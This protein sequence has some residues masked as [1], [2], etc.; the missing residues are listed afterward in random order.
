[1]LTQRLTLNMGKWADLPAELATQVLR[2]LSVDQNIPR[3]SRL[4]FT[5]PN[6]SAQQDLLSCTYVSHQFYSIVTPLL[7][8]NVYLQDYFLDYRRTI[9]L[10]PRI[11]QF[12]RALVVNPDFGRH[13]R[14]LSVPSLGCGFH[15]FTAAL[16]LW[17]Q[18]VDLDDLDHTCLEYEVDLPDLT[19]ILDA[20]QEMGLS[21]GLVL[22]GRQDGIFITLLH[23]LPKLQS[24]YIEGGDLDLVAYSCFGV[25]GGIP[26]S[27]Q[28]IVDL[29]IFVRDIRGED[30][31]ADTEDLIPF[32]T[33]PSLQSITV[34][35]F[36]G[37]PSRVLLGGSP[38]RSTQTSP[39]SG[40]LAPT[41]TT[42]LE[43]STGYAITVKSSPVTSLRFW[44]SNTS[45]LNTPLAPNRSALPLFYLISQASCLRELHITI[46]GSDRFWEA[47]DPCIGSLSEMT[48][49]EILRLPLPVL[50]SINPE[51]GSFHNH[52]DEYYD[53]DRRY[54]PLP[55]H[56]FT[57]T[58]TRNP[59]DDLLPPNL[60]LLEIDVGKRFFPQFV[61]RTG[62]PQ[63]LA[64]TRTRIPLLESFVVSGEP[65][66]A[67][68]VRQLLDQ[69]P[70]L[71]PP[72]NVT[73]FGASNDF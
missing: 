73:L 53:G 63:S 32:L 10:S 8:R 3:G 54:I 4:E 60:K 17:N 47:D 25:F 36:Y 67:R 11:H 65:Y 66:D 42:F 20:L 34:C 72:M 48:A 12:T 15:D 7:Y 19:L 45:F 37:G 24:L 21:S 5:A 9:H 31:G 6:I 59:I 14:R 13:V 51:E 28:S 1:M 61:T 16:D 44:S 41:P 22:H 18:S 52:R 29:S 27:L 39:P 56:S 69:M 50:L 68:V 58:M 46:E 40:A 71:S 64:L 70:K 23:L 35:K 49:L 43:T 26:V 30:G 33:L 55:E 62:F 38:P 2:D 57:T